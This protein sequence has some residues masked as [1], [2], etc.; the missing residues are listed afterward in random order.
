MAPRGGALPVVLGIAAGAC[1]SFVIA[2]PLVRSA[3]AGDTTAELSV[4]RAH[5]Q[6]LKGVLGA[7]AGQSVVFACDAGMG[8]SVI[9]A[10]ILRRKLRDAGVPAAVTHAAIGELPQ[11]A[12]IVVVHTSLADR[13]RL[14][15]PDAAVYAIDEFVGSPVYDAIVDALRTSAVSSMPA[16]GS[17]PKKARA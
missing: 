6:S 9:G 3:A 8:S 16:E 7:Q 15:A 5:S 2:A 12:T 4:A 11:G 17:S 14:A 1:V 10:S 13:A